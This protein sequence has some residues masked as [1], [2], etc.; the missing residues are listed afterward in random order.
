MTREFRSRRA[1]I[2]DVA[3]RAD[4]ALGTV[5]RII[6]GNATVTPELRDH[7]LKVIEELDYRPNTTARTLRTKRTQAVGI[8]VTDIRQPIAAEM[9]AAA[10]KVVR[11]RGFAPIVGD[12]HND[13]ESERLLLRFMAERSVDGLLITI[14]SDENASLIAELK[15]LG[16][17][18]VLWERDAAGVFSFSAQR[19]SPRHPTGRRASA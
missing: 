11:E 19:S 5:S 10:G 6:N 8:I 7:V 16:V 13:R 12:F 1:T 9:I 15:K 3:I 14:S 4:V 17:P 2:K 18:V